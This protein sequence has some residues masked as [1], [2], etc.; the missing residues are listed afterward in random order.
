MNHS[1]DNFHSP[2]NALLDQKCSVS[3]WPIPKH[4]K[5]NFGLYTYFIIPSC[6]KYKVDCVAP[7]NQIFS[8]YLS[9]VPYTLTCKICLLLDFA[10]LWKKTE[11]FHEMLIKAC[12]YYLNCFFFNKFVTGF[13]N[14]EWDLKL[15]ANGLWDKETR[16]PGV[17]GTLPV[18]EPLTIT[19]GH[20]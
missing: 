14:K 20:G 17:H 16:R 18:Q 13:G 10:V 8:I 4:S 19:K 7:V 9:L 2:V 5:I 6:S 1:L 15:I 12:S 11:Y 3:S